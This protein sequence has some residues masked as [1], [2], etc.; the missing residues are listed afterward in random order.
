MDN[1]YLLLEDFASELISARIPPETIYRLKRDHIGK[2]EVHP[3]IM[4][5]TRA[6]YFSIGGADEDF[7]GHYGHTDP[8]I[9]WK[10]QEMGVSVEHFPS[11]AKLQPQSEKYRPSRKRDASHN[12]RIFE[13]KKEW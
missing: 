12:L 13:S 5:T 9:V 4:F 8:H 2:S 7:V 3:D 11:E 10:A 1:D 6:A